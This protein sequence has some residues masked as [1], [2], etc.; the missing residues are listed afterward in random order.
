[1]KT[2]DQ[3]LTDLHRVVDQIERVV[4]GDITVHVGGAQMTPCAAQATQDALIKYLG[5]E[6]ALVSEALIKHVGLESPLNVI[7]EVMELGERLTTAVAKYKNAK[8]KDNALASIL[9]L[10]VGGTTPTVNLEADIEA[11]EQDAR[12]YLAKLG[13]D[14]VNMK[15]TSPGVFEGYAMIA[16]DSPIFDV[17][18]Q[19]I[20]ASP[21]NTEKGGTVFPEEHVGPASRLHRPAKQPCG[22]GGSEKRRSAQ[23]G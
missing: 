5:V 17:N 2:F 12:D 11:T 8:S 10:M 7:H 3:L 15:E 21:F 1:M 23:G 4:D 22:C 9:G 20:E 13:I 16:Q 18:S 14:P 6:G 19:G